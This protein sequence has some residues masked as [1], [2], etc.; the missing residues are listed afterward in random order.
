M[1]QNLESLLKVIN[2]A[3]IKSDKLRK[4][5][6][7][8]RLKSYRLTKEDIFDI[9]V[10]LTPEEYEK[11]KDKD[12]KLS[13]IDLAN[14]QWAYFYDRKDVNLFSAEKIYNGKLKEYYVSVTDTN[15]LYTEKSNNL[16]PR[17][18]ASG[19]FLV[20]MLDNVL[21]FSNVLTGFVL[22]GIHF[23][24]NYVSVDASSNKADE[25]YFYSSESSGH[26]R[27]FIDQLNSYEIIRVNLH[28]FK[29]DQIYSETVNDKKFTFKYYKPSNLKQPYTVLQ[30]ISID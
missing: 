28:T 18:N 27:F 21:S 10:K 16:M 29:I 24:P 23:Y 19:K 2:K 17:F 9:E 5:L 1:K 11:Y 3:H 15:S 30:S 6:G 25:V 26:T 7:F 4:K 12:I 14:R 8:A 22:N 13:E 20:E